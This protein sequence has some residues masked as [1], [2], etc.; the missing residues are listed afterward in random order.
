MSFLDSNSNSSGFNQRQN[1][2]Q[3]SGYQS[4]TS[5]SG[6]YNNIL[7]AIRSFS[8]NVTNF[9]NSI[10]KMGTKSDNPQLRQNM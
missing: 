2:F 3:E 10:F 6:S 8:N 7:N 4:G 5:Y 9:T 1:P